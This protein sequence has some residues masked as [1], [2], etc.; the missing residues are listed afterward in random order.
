MNVDDTKDRIYIHDLDAELASVS[1]AD[2]DERVIF[3]P[4]IERNL[5][6]VPHQVLESES[7]DDATGQEMVLYSVP[8]SLSVPE[9]QDS[10]R[11]AIL[12]SR[13]RTREQQQRGDVQLNKKALSQTGAV[14][15]SQVQQHHQ[16]VIIDYD[17]D[18]MDI[19]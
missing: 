4:D 16:E 18:A 5:N 14:S 10:V 12:E 13:A 15:Q 8:H 9:G 11:K 2:E 3:L 7:R 19:G 6:R 17:P 1:D